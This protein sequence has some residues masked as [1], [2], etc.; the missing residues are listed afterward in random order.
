MQ[1]SETRDLYHS[2]LMTALTEKA[3]VDQN[4]KGSFAVG[5]AR[6]DSVTGPLQAGASLCR[7]TPSRTRTAIL[8]GSTGTECC[9]RCPSRCLRCRP[10]QDCS[11][12]IS[13]AKRDAHCWDRR[14]VGYTEK[15]GN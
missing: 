12:L 13:F 11:P 7:E 15:V 2:Y 6:A 4:F 10:L 14:Y 3:T 5:V 9:G 8:S 1:V